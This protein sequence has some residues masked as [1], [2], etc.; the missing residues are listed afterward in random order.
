MKYTAILAVGLATAASASIG[1]RDAAPYKT[2]VQSITTAV[3]NLDSVVQQYSGGDKQPVLESS[4]ALVK[5]LDDG[6]TTIDGLANLTAGDAGALL[7]DLGTLSTK[8]QT[9]TS[10]LKSKRGEVEQA[11]ECAAVRNA[12][13]EINTSAKALVTTA[14]GKI[15]KTFQSLAQ[16]YVSDFT[17]SFQQTQDY[18]STANCQDGAGNGTSTATTSGATGSAT[19]SQTAAASPSGSSGA[20]SMMAPVWTLGTAMAVFAVYY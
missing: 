8:S 18:F 9:L 5:A 3:D 7:G 2:V 15:P 14:V 17:N 1:A 13:G 12:M 6:K 4:S 19:G 11:G 20:A 10:D 16:G